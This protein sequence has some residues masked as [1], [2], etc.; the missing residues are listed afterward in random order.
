M[1]LWRRPAC[2]TLF[3]ALHM[4][5]AIAWVAPDLLKALVF[6]LN[7]IVGRSPV[8]QKNM[9]P[10][11]KSEKKAIFLKEVISKHIIYKFFKH[12]ISHRMKSNRVLDFSCSRRLPNFLKYR[13]HRWYLLTIW[14]RRFL[15]RHVEKLS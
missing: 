1:Y 15:Q 8:E 11:W 5:S 13:Y 6:L 9:K 10:Y 7:T 2:Q 14:K 4:S 12:F 3:K